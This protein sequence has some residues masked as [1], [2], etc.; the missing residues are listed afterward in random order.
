MAPVLPTTSPPLLRPSS[1]AGGA[2]PANNIVPFQ[3]P[4]SLTAVRVIGTATT[5]TAATGAIAAGGFAVG[6]EL[7]F[8]A[9]VADATRTGAESRLYQE[10][11]GAIRS[12]PEHQLSLFEK[13]LKAALN[14]AQSAF[15]G[16]TFEVVQGTDRLGQSVL[17]LRR[18]DTVIP[19]IEGS[20][21]VTNPVSRA[22]GSSTSAEP[23]SPRA[24]ADAAQATR[25]ETARLE[26]QARQEQQ[27]AQAQVTAAWSGP[28]VADLQRAY[29]SMGQFERATKPTVQMNGVDSDRN[30]LKD[31]FSVETAASAIARSYESAAQHA[32]RHNSKAAPG[33]TRMVAFR[34]PDGPRAP[35]LI[36]TGS[37]SEIARLVQDGVVSEGDLAAS[38]LSVQG[39]Q[40]RPKP[41]SPGK[42]PQAPDSPPKNPEKQRE[43]T[44]PGAP[45]QPPHL[46][47]PGTT[48]AI[49]RPE[50]LRSSPPPK[51]VPAPGSTHEFGTSVPQGKPIP[52]FPQ[53]PP[54]RSGNQPPPVKPRQE[55]PSPPPPGDGAPQKPGDLTVQPI[56]TPAELPVKPSTATPPGDPTFKGP[57]SSAN[58]AFQRP[59][60][61]GTP[62]R[63]NANPIDTGG[64]DYEGR[65][66]TPVPMVPVRDEFGNVVKDK[67][68]RSIWIPIMTTA[69]VPTRVPAPVVIPSTVKP[70]HDREASIPPGD[71]PP[72]PYV[73]EGYQYAMFEGLVPRHQVP[74]V[75]PGRSSSF[76]VNIYYHRL[77]DVNRPGTYRVDLRG[78]GSEKLI[79]LAPPDW[80]GADPLTLSDLEFIPESRWKRA[81]ATRKLNQLDPTLDTPMDRNEAEDIMK[82]GHFPP[83]SRR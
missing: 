80:N 33:D 41:V 3:T 9:S 6:L 13:Q 67:E 71:G 15:P 63:K 61:S 66:P 58:P 37:R 22:T 39:L 10:S 60:P 16:Q 42:A 1:G 47:T 54:E 59:R 17:A 43:W 40:A 79:G 70:I 62:E 44:A 51:P 81:V 53:L 11:L 25:R 19:L 52:P 55:P 77:L 73:K 56:G 72:L 8:P 20:R 32:F 29:G 24:V 50:D 82:R 69:E 21:V 30:G 27:K 12:K 76:Q 2:A 46:P 65:I 45:P 57:S 26:A 78:A 5:A 83:L 18:G 28:V 35:V 4:S 36:F 31:R 49:P 75:A 7:A 74:Q 64:P 14:A 38:G 68:G 48:V 34:H 23:T